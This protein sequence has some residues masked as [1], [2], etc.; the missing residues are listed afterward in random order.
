MIG[1]NQGKKTLLLRGRSCAFLI[2]FIKIGTENN[3]FEALLVKP[4]SGLLF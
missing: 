3:T 1:N 2:C 4:Q